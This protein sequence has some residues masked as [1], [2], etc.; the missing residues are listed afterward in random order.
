[1]MH[2]HEKMDEEKTFEV[3]QE[4][5]PRQQTSFAPVS[6]SLVKRGLTEV[7]AMFDRNG[8][9]YLDETERALRRMDS[10]DKGYLGID[11]VCVIFESLQSE[12]ERSSQLL[13]ALRTE[14]KK[15]L[16]LKM[17]VIA[18]T[19]FSVLLALANIG[20][21]FAVATLVKDMKV[22]TSGD[23]LTKDSNVRVGTTAKVVSFEIDAI[24]DT[25]RRRLQTAAGLVCNTMVDTDPVTGLTDKS[26]QLQGTIKNTVADSLHG[27]LKVVDHVQLTCNSKRSQLF[28]TY[29]LPAGNPGDFDMGGVPYVIYPTSVTPDDKYQAIQS[30]LVPHQPA[31]PA[32]PAQN[33]FPAIPAQAAVPEH[34]C[35]A[36][37]SLAFY[38]MKDLVNGVEPD[39]LVM[40]AFQPTEA[41][42]TSPVVC[43]PP[44]ATNNGV[45]ST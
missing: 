23:L 3:I 19:V 16:N 31:V 6:P 10:Q 42:K 8:K 37:F 27:E 21:S 14:S 33:G 38:C 17:G 24:D 26:C 18:L 34:N 1:M 30:V 29:K 35:D 12:Q 7:S 32:T 25:R 9:G 36:Y 5:R 13:E 4:D 15:S 45:I 28:G 22:D 40:S 44:P 39:C 2:N 41:C 11:K 43:G 20:T